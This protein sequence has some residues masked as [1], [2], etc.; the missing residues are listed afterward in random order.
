[1]FVKRAIHLLAFTAAS[2]ALTSVG[3]A[4]AD[5]EWA[6]DAKVQCVQQNWPTVKAK[7]DPLLNQASPS[8]RQMLA[9]FIG[10]DGMLIDE[11]SA[12][13]IRDA[14]GRIPSNALDTVFAGIC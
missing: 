14:A 12:D 11:P 1:M 4:S 9:G 6:T 3:V 13:Q 5:A 7:Y 2:L 8:D 10:P